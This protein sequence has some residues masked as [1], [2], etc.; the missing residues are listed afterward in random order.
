MLQAIIVQPV[1]TTLVIV[2]VAYTVLGVVR[3]LTKVGV[4]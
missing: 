1:A 2:G 4:V 3:G